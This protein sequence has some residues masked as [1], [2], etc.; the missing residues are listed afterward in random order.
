MKNILSQNEVDELLSGFQ[1]ETDKSEHSRKQKLTKDDVKTLQLMHESLG[2][3]LSEK[4]SILFHNGVEIILSQI[5]K[6]PA[7]TMKTIDEF[8]SVSGCF[9]FGNG[10]GRYVLDVS[11]VYSIIE[12]LLGGSGVSS[13]HLQ[14]LTEIEKRIYS[15]VHDVVLECIRMQWERHK[16]SL[17]I[18]DKAC[19]N[20]KEIERKLDVITV[21]MQIVLD[22]GMKGQMQLYYPLNSLLE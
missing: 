7:S 16:L 5:K 3:D 14:A 19:E 20:H 6:H 17:E 8:S 11:L 9:E 18:I 2:K 1:T 4:L 10:M 22:P 21:T 13:Y 12:R 15:Q